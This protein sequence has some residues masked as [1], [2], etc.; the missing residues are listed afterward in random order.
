MDIEK[1]IAIIPARGGSKRILR[2]NIAEIGG[3]P[4]I[5]YAIDVCL[6]SNLFSQVYINSDD[7]EILDIAKKYGVKAYLRPE[8][9][10]F[11]DVY[12]IDVLK[13]MINSLNLCHNDLGILLPTSPLRIPEDLIGAWNLYKEK[14]HTVVS[15]CKYE[16]PVQLSQ[17]INEDGRLYPFFPE[18]YN[19]TTRSYGHK[20][21]FRY[22]G[23]IIFNSALNILNQ[24]NLIGKSPYSFIMP[25]ERSIDI[26][27]KYQ[28]EMVRGILNKK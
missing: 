22:N 8:K 26:D 18:E 7:R 1:P 6:E 17:F 2:K 10:A 21:S 12:I 27:S 11:D 24:T 25:E 13:E 19:K 16:T 14:K 5:Y 23:A 9:L 20:E 15:V 3:T 4:L 28:L